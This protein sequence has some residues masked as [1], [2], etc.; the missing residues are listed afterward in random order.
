[1]AE[2]TR[3]ILDGHIVL[4][5][6][7]ADS[8]HY[9]AIDV[10]ASTSRLF[11]S[12]AGNQHIDDANKLRQLITRYREIEFLLQVGEYKE[13]GD[14]LADV[15]LQKHGDIEAFLC[16]FATNSFPID[17]TLSQ[18]NSLVEGIQP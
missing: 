18:L 8:G 2:E 5:R 13:G 17:A 11:Q 12:L 9:P 15:A 16:Q 7:L 3:S 1:M 10:P 6:K 14:S 4:S